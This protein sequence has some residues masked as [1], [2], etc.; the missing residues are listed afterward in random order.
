MTLSNPHAIPTCWV[1]T[2]GAAGNRR[3][4]LA[5]ADAIGITYREWQLTT[6][7]PWRWLAPRTLR[8]A[9][10]AFGNEFAG[11]LARAP[12]LAI[13]CGRQAAL[14]TRLLRLRGTIAVQILDPRTDPAAWDVVIAPAHDRLEAGNVINVPGSLSP[15][16]PDWLAQGRAQFAHLGDL[17][18]PRIAVLIG[19]KS[20]HVHFDH[21][22]FE[23]MAAQIDNVI[24]KQGGS[25]MV[26]TSR[27][28]P[29]SIR[30]VLAYRYRVTPG[31]VWL[32]N[33]GANPYAGI[34]G[35]AD[36]I[37]CSPDSVNMISEACATSVPVFVANPGL[38]KGR[39][40]NFLDGL[41][42]AGQIRPQDPLLATYA[43][44]PLQPLPGIA[45]FLRH[46]WPELDVV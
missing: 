43:R 10:Q 14:A 4:A 17:P 46:R 35:W 11:E 34:L 1:L 33:H 42:K 23:T 32:G 28:T 18:S 29:K 7:P 27:R 15:I 5:L 39:I 41:L 8:G 6:R 9:E 40:K 24:A 21:K 16:N 31:I 44:Q 19:G 37:I 22:A 2:D 26:T 12:T 20:K 36:K 38:V 45:D 13:G 25:V 30:D 3:Q